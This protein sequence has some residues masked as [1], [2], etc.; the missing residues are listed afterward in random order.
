MRTPG[1]T[2]TLEALRAEVSRSRLRA[3]SP[4]AA[5]LVR[6][7]DVRMNSNTVLATAAQGVVDDPPGAFA[8][9]LDAGAPG[10][11]E[12]ATACDWDGHFEVVRAG[13]APT[14][15]ALDAAEFVTAIDALLQTSLS[16]YGFTLAEPV[17]LREEFLFDELGGAF[18]GW[19]FYEADVDSLDAR[20]DYFDHFGNDRCL[21]WS[22]GRTLRVLFTNG[23]D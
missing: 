23:S 6:A 18:E 4:G 21:F 15:R 7:L 17:A 2:L 14:V 11:R 16:F 5:L 12:A 8:R 3:L 9:W 10:L 19:R 13:A 1:S 22:D 20:F